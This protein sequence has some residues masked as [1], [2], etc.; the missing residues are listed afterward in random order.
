MDENVFFTSSEHYC[1]L[2]K[3]DKVQFNE[4]VRNK[5]IDFITNLLD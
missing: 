5:K 2:A 3:V 1:E 4:I